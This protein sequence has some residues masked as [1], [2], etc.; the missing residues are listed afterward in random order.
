MP[1]PVVIRLMQP[2][3][4]AQIQMLDAR[5]QPY[6]PEDQPAVEAMFERAKDVEGNSDRWAP[7]PQPGATSE[8]D[9]DDGYLA[10]WV[11]AVR[12]E[13]GQ[14]HI[15]GMVGV[16]PM[17]FEILPKSGAFV[18]ALRGKESIL[19]LQ[20]L[21]V[22]PDFHGRGIGQMLCQEVI[23]W[24]RDHGCQSLYVN[25]TTP[26]TPARGL[27]QKLGFREVAV[28]YVGKY[29]LVWMELTLQELK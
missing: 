27:Y 15:A 23:D 16:G 11:A 17:S 2:S 10:F 4:A 25:T 28:T 29:E 8:E 18:A 24:A 7:I 21:R 1:K 5:V 13:D 6:R 26:Q 22:D 14:E 20:H 19:E 12:S 9:G 3:D